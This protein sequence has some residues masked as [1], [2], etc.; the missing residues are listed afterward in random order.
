MRLRR[1]LLRV[2]YRLLV[3]Y[4]RAR[5]DVRDYPVTAGDL[6]GHVRRWR[7]E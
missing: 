7:G 4:V 3:G 6:R 2:V 5:H 1:V